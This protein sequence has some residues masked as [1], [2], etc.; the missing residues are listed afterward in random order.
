[1]AKVTIEDISRET[2]L[3]RGTVSRALNDRPD[4]SA[5]TKQKVLDACRQ[6]NYVPS[7]AARSLATGRS[8]VVVGVVECL[9]DPTA[10]T[11]L[12][13]IL[14]KAESAGYALQILE[15]GSDPELRRTRLNRLPHERADALLFHTKLSEQEQSMLSEQLGN[16][17]IAAHTDLPGIKADRFA[18]DHRESGRITARHLI[19]RAGQKIAYVRTDQSSNVR[20][21]GFCDIMAQHGVPADQCV[22]T[23]APDQPD[24][25]SI[26]HERLPMLDGIAADDD[27][28]AAAVMLAAGRQG[29]QPG[30]NLAIV[31]QGNS[32]LA[33]ALTPALTSIDW[34]AE[35]AGERGMTR[36]L[37]RVAK[38]YTAAPDATAVAPRL[39]V[40]A[41]SDI[42]R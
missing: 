29:R 36:I 41:S 4:I 24:G 16:Q 22:I 8:F 35:E 37:E 32:A 1:M 14:S 18:P 40:R 2:G 26:L 6:L 28:L 15:L 12:R 11:F 34:G 3:S 30:S 7:K 23:V 39:V 20:E 5:V 33:S 42:A 19:E 31:G 17:P 10:G 38:T 9:N 21:A 13:G 27:R 25:F